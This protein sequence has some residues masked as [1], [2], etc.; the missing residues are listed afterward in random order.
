MW[1]DGSCPRDVEE[2]LVIGRH[3]S[4]EL[5]L[6][7]CPVISSSPFPHL[8][9]SSFLI[10]LPLPSCRA[11]PLPSPPFLCRLILPISSLQHLNKRVTVSM[12]ACLNCSLLALILFFLTSLHFQRSL[13]TTV[14]ASCTLHKRLSIS[15][16]T[17]AEKLLV[18]SEQAN[19]RVSRRQ[20]YRRGRST[21]IDRAIVTGERDEV[22]SS[23]CPD[24]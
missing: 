24:R 16:N 21:R 1:C 10:F 20:L 14:L 13:L 8:P 18:R 15:Q 4:H 11:L 2:L 6:P 17:V 12:F 22:E 3:V 9:S 5:F 7:S 19:E 23:A